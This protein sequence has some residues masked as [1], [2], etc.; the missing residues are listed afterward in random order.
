MANRAGRQATLAGLFLA[1]AMSAAQ[2][3]APFRI[4]MVDDLSGVFSGNESG[5]PLTQG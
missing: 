2:A 5:C 4:G 3:Q 1:G